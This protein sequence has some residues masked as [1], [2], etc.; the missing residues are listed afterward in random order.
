MNRN[1]NTFAGN[2][3]AYG[4]MAP[5]PPTPAY[6]RAS[7]MNAQIMQP[8]QMPGM[9]QTPQQ[10]MQTPFAGPPQTGSGGYGGGGGVDLQSALAALNGA[11]PQPNNLQPALGQVNTALPPNP[12]QVLMQLMQ[13]LKGQ[14]IY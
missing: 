11:I 7:G 14:G 3:Q 1:L 8:T 10:P 12:Q 4:R 5:Q 9:Y 13:L 2:Q 6:Q